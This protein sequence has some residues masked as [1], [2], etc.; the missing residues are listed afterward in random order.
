MGIIKSKFCALTLYL[1]IFLGV[2]F[3]SLTEKCYAEEYLSD[4]SIQGEP[5]YIV[6]NTIIKNDRILGKTFQ[7]DILL[8][9]TGNLKS[10]EIEVNL[11]DEEGYAISQRTY[12]EPGETKTISFTWSTINIRNQILKVSFYP[13]DLD[14]LWNKYNSGYKTFTIKVDENG[15]PATSTPGFEI[16]LTIIAIIGFTYLMKRNG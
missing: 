3:Y 6:T 4:I 1:I 9:N 10:D 16:L 14:T 15:I 12:F 2:T 11:T 8:S 13:S 5:T 7:I